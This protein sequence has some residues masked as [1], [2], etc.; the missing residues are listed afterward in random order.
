MT[1]VHVAMILRNEMARHLKKAAECAT[2]VAALNGGRFIVTDDR[3]D[4][5]TYEFMREFTTR[6]QRFDHP[7][8]MKNE[9]VARQLHYEWIS[10]H[11]QPGDWVLSLDADETVNDPRLVGEKVQEAER[12]R[13]RVVLMPLYEFWSESPPMYRTD[14]YWFGTKASRLYQFQDGG[15]MS[16]R[17]FAGGSEPLYVGEEARAG[18]VLSQDDLHLLHWG[19]VFTR[20]RVVKYERYTSREGGH[21]HNDR[22][23]RS[24]ID[25]SPE[26]ARYLS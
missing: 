11:V 21:G 18:R 8:F 26:L 10:T 1:R 12:K 9:G 2:E 3:S 15:R 19:Y 5:G 25:P 20:D 24:I 6:I 22:H 7:M 23:V 4:D 17:E 13:R 14:G 16:D